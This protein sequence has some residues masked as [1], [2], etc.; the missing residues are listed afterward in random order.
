MFIILCISFAEIR[1]AE[2]I[3]LNISG[4]NTNYIDIKFFRSI[5]RF[6]VIEFNND[7]ELLYK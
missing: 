2:F 1:P 5:E 4:M 6:L 3:C 7:L